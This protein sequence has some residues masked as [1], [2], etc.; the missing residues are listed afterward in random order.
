VTARKL[1]LVIDGEHEGELPAGKGRPL[2]RLTIPH[3]LQAEA[4]L[5]KP[6]LAGRAVWTPSKP[7][8]EACQLHAVVSQHGPLL[9]IP[10]ILAGYPG[11]WQNAEAMASGYCL[12]RTVNDPK[13]VGG[14]RVHDGDHGRV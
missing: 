8:A 5:G 13:G 9:S 6:S 3:K 14:H 2:G 7:M 4:R 11:R 12:P 1:R 10:D